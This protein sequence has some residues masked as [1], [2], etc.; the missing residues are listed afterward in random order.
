MWLQHQLS[1]VSFYVLGTSSCVGKVSRRSLNAI[2]SCPQLFLLPR[3]TCH[4]SWEGDAV[5][6]S[7][8]ELWHHILRL[9]RMYAVYQSHRLLSV[10]PQCSV[11][12]CGVSVRSPRGGGISLYPYATASSALCFNSVSH[13][14]QFPFH[15]TFC[16]ISIISGTLSFAD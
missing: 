14:Y 6:L 15:S 8:W 11:C 13:L 10:R 3:V 1:E 9:H 5:Q 16:N 2:Y 7:L 12:V 4:S